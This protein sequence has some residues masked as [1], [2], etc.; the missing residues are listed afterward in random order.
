MPPSRGSSL[1]NTGHY[2]GSGTA[3]TLAWGASEFVHSSGSSYDHPG[4]T[5]F[6]TC[7]ILLKWDSFNTTILFIY[8]FI[9]DLNF[10]FIF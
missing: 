5:S 10:Y 6:M 4:E 2:L 9:H 7:F 1:G 8:L 3:C